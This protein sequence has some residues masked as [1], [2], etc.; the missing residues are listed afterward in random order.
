[1]SAWFR[2]G[3]GGTNHIGRI[4]GVS[5]FLRKVRT[6]SG[7][8]A[9]QVVEKKHGQRRILEHLGSA[10]SEAE[11]AALVEIGIQKLNSGQDRLDLGADDQGSPKAAGAV[12]RGSASR[13]LVDVVRRSWDRLG[14]GIVDDEAFFQLVL[15]RLVEPT[16]KLD[17]LR[18]I[19]E[20]GLPV[21]HRNTFN[22]ALRRCADKAYRQHISKACFDHV[23]T[24]AGGDIS[25]LLYDVTTLYFEAE[26]EDDLRKSGYSKERRVDP[27]ILVGLLVDRTG[28]PL[29][30]ACFEGSKAETLTILPVVQAFQERHQ[31]ADMVVVAD[32]GMLSAKNLQDIDEAQL[33]FIVGSRTTKAPH[34]LVKH[35]HWHGNNFTDGQIIDTITLKRWKSDPEV[36]KSR[37]EPV[38][39]PEEHANAWRAIWSYSE[40][41]A[42]RDRYTLNQQRNKAIGIIEDGKQTRK[43]RFVKTSGT[44]LTFDEATYQR[45]EALVGLKGYVT[46]I[47][48]TV[49]PAAEVISSYHDLWHVEQSFRMSKHDLAA[50]PIYHRTREAIEAHLTIVFAALAIARDLQA[51]TGWSVRKLIQTLRPLRHVTIQINGQTIEAA[52]GIPTDVQE[53]LKRAGH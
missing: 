53:I 40:K 11:L 31:V 3:C 15:A 13:L 29:E 2:W 22:K 21:P 50:R 34:D 10:H 16:S 9:V 25:L 43:T 39:D 48:A 14:F 45:A 33:R 49:M 23:W 4:G 37:S 36:L 44:T 52:P 35:F 7:A 5:P 32:A 26:K 38:W 41:R 27:Q 18:V 1:M 8:T 24:G 20:L 51:R 47:T 46:N 6:A 42:A 19:G 28:F 30:I 17:S 12:V